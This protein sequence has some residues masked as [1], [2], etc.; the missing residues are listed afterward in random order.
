MTIHWT[1]SW[2][3]IRKDRRFTPM[4]P[5]RRSSGSL[6][7]A[8]I[9]QRGAITN[10]SVSLT[11]SPEILQTRLVNLNILKR[12]WTDRSEKA[13]NS[14]G[15]YSNTLSFNCANCETSARFPVPASIAV[16][17]VAVMNSWSDQ[18]SIWAN[19]M[20][21]LLEPFFYIVLKSKRILRRCSDWNHF[22][23]FV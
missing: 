15:I 19:K 2:K 4:A 5:N 12:W 3:L 13:R 11:V 22:F 10:Y 6:Y 16:E 8:Y 21:Q 7:T 18:I 1:S 17:G 9:L 20:N 14:Q 23:I